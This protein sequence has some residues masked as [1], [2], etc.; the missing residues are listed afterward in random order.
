MT[1]ECIYGHIVDVPPEW[2]ENPTIVIS[3]ERSLRNES[4]TMY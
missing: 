3:S 2:Q 4:E 1:A